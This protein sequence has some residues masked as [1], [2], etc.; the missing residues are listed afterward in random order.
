MLLSHPPKKY[1]LELRNAVRL[2][3]G[4][5]QWTFTNRNYV[6]PRRVRIGPVSVTS[7]NH[8]RNVV[9]LSES[10]RDGSNPYVMRTDELKRVLCVVH[11]ESFTTPPV[12][13]V[14]G[15][16]EQSTQ[17]GTDASIAAI[18]NVIA[19]LDYAPSRTFDSTFTSS[20]VG[21]P[22]VQYIYN[23]AS[24]SELIM[25]NSY[26]S[27]M[28]LANLGN[29]LALT[30]TGNWE[31]SADSQPMAVSDLSEQFSVHSIIRLANTSWTYFW[32][33]YLNKTLMWGNP[34][35]LSYYDASDARQS[36]S[37]IN[38]IPNR[39]YLL[40]VTR[41]SDGAGAYN[42]EYRVEDLDDSTATPQTSTVV[43][44]GLPM[45]ANP[46][47]WR[48][49]HASTHFQH[50]MGPF[51]Y[52]KGAVLA[53]QEDC[54][55]WL[56]NHIGSSNTESTTSE[57]TVSN[58]WYQLYDKRMTQIDIEQSSSSKVQKSLTVSFEDHNGNLFTPKDAILHMEIDRS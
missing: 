21:G 48:F 6:R 35:V 43:G 40:S 9:L 5:Y 51:F 58:S 42:F 53:E 2:S 18:T 47:N 52:L 4:V 44:A 24:N 1:L 30:R 8:L 46:Q 16:T 20:T 15:Q 37:G 23:R 3:E 13:T 56:R 7:E 49:G 29:G 39:N 31:S 10:F 32:D 17:P 41:V 25:T 36:V 34:A 57:T 50:Y 12:E 54:R 19:W 28:S 27:G 45:Q 22:L 33:L 26:G 14:A 11:G 55:A 38:M